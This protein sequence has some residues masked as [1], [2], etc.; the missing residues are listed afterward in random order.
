MPRSALASTFAI[1]FKHLSPRMASLPVGWV[2]DKH[3]RIDPQ[4]QLHKN[5]PENQERFTTNTLKLCRAF[6]SFS[7]RPPFPSCRVL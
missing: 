7:L 5:A 1:S 2:S 3:V 4:V 6:Q